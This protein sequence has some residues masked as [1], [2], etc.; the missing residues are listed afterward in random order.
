MTACTEKEDNGTTTTEEP[1]TVTLAGTSWVGTVT[2][3]PAEFNPEWD[4]L[5]TSAEYH[6]SF[7]DG[8]N[9]TLSYRMTTLFSEGDTPEEYTEDDTTEMT[10]TFDG[11]ANGT[12]TADG[13]LTPFRYNKADNT[14]VLSIEYTPELGVS[15]IVLHRE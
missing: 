10:Y 13:E 15:E 11:T 1:T 8:Q 2:N 6:I 14:I 7:T 9:G 3:D 12:I 4:V 5:I